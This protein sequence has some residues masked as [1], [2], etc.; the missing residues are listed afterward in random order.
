MF[1]ADDH[2]LIITHRL[3]GMARA[4]APQLFGHEAVRAAV[5][6]ELKRAVTGW[7]R[8][9]CDAGDGYTVP[10]VLC[11]VPVVLRVVF[12]RDDYGRPVVAP[13]GK[14]TIVYATHAY[15]AERAA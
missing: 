11:G 13:D 9:R 10:A 8:V 5:F 4:V 2:Y 12:A 6:C 15:A 14:K 7:K 1:R 3:V